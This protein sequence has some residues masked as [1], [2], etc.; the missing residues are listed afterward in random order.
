MMSTTE[1]EMGPAKQ[2]ET[3]SGGNDPVE[4]AAEESFP[5]SDP[6]AWTPVTG[7]GPPA[8]RRTKA[9]EVRRDLRSPSIGLLPGVVGVALL[10][11]PGAPLP[12]RA[13]G[14]I[15]ISA[16]VL[17]VATGMKFPG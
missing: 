6:P 14:V 11:W 9:E 12:V 13:M 10:I 16:G 8:R 7:I 2:Q 3:S 17:L 1:A 15:A 4:E 5:A